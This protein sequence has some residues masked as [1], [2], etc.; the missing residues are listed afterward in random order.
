MTTV[1][2][3][4]PRSDALLCTHAHYDHAAGMRAVQDAIGRRHSG[5]IP[6]TVRSSMRL[7]E[8]GA[9]FGFP[10]A[11]RRDG[12]HDLVDGQTD[13]DRRRERSRCSTRPGTRRGVSLPCGRDG[14]GSGT[15]CSRARSVAPICPAGRSR[16]LE[17]SIRT[18]LF[19]LG[20]AHPASIPATVPPTTIGTR[21][22][23]QPV[24]GR[25]RG[26]A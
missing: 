25:A 18:R 23:A 9:T 10:P 20:D 5:S 22:A 15:C 17:R 14:C 8:Q 6:P 2:R 16:S 3:A 26:F 4:E 12:V 11:G 21:A 7:S 19:P 24:R 13:R 1:Q